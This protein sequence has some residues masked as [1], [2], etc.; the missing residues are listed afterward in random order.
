M[1][2]ETKSDHLNYIRLVITRL[3]EAGFTTNRMTNFFGRKEDRYLGFLI[4]NRGI[5][6]DLEKI[7]PITDYPTPKNLKQL[8]KFVGM[9]PWYRK[10]IR[11][12]ATIC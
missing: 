8:R 4:D 12:F 9:C 3:N 10:F 6:T 7:R 2:S 11:D 5:K 1:S